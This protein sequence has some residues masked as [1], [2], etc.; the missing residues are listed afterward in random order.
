MNYRDFIRL[1]HNR[2]RLP[3]PV[4][5]KCLCA[6]RSLRDLATNGYCSRSGADR[7]D[8]M[9]Y[10]IRASA[11]GLLAEGADPDD[12]ETWAVQ[13]W[14]RECERLNNVAANASQIERGPYVGQSS[15][16]HIHGN[17]EVMGSDIQAVIETV[18]TWL[19]KS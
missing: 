18:Q 19:K 4:K 2:A 12:V 13:T 10:D 3:A 8:A 11:Y 16:H 17:P 15:L 7:S 9:R 14:A 5:D 1:T 6:A